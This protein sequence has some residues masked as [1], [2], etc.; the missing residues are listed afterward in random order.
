MT[1]RSG[2]NEAHGRIYD[3]L[4]NDALNAR[5]FFQKSR[6]RI[7]QNE[8]GATLGGPVYLP[9]LYNGRNRTFFFFGQQLAYWDQVGSGALITAPRADF[10]QGD[11]SALVN[12]AGA[13]TP[14]FDPATTR[15]DGKG[16]ATRDPFP[17]NVLPASRISPVSNRILALIPQPDLPAQQ[18]ANFYNRTGGGSYRDSISTV[19]LDH[20]FSTSHKIAITYSD[21]YDPR[22]IA[23]QGWG[24]ASPLEGSQAPKTIHDRTG[25]IND[26]YIIRNNLLNHFTLGV[27]R[28]RN[29]TRQVSQFEGWDAKLGIQGVMGDQG[30]FPVITFSG[31][32]A[33]PRGLGGPDFSTNTGGRITLSDT[34]T[35]IK[36]RHSFRFGANYWPEYANA[37]EG[38]LSSGSFAFSN[39]TTSLPN[40]PQYTSWGSSFASF[41][42]GD[43]ASGAVAE[44]YTRGAR[45]RSGG[46]FAQDEWRA[47]ANL[48]VSYGL[49]W[50]WNAAPFEP[51]GAASGF[52]P[53]APNPA[54][55]GRPGA[56]VFAGSGPGRTG[57]RSLSDGW[58]RGF[59]PRLGVAY[60]LTPKNV[61]KGSFSV[62][63]APGFRTRLIA[64]GLNNAHTVSSPNGYNPAYNWGTSFPQDFPRAPFIDPS[65][66]NDQSVSSILPGTSRMPQIATWTVSLEHAISPNLA[67][68]A[69][70]IGSHSTHLILSDAAIEYEYA[71]C[72]PA[73]ARRPAV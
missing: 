40:A 11:F 10:R 4:D 44:P 27:D 34:L 59:G 23:G 28:Y 17:G 18:D 31:G 47:T 50:E 14:V 56:L 25:R 64:Y 6:T 45:F 20:N 13:I 3:Y 43:L 39:L 73:S 42:L 49:R 41:L 35:W 52:G 8:G 57:S 19:K 2:T 54:A 62:Y 51:N 26:D 38:Y 66:Q 24:A 65:Y 33:I 36:G 15:P 48:T 22:V 21:Q 69:T 32:I 53:A 70:Y 5:A 30:A 60:A 61:A 12:A 46:A 1:I 7:R 37:R 71:R 16:G 67:V 68:E 58:Y 72:Q 9:G 55:G 63:Y 29:Q